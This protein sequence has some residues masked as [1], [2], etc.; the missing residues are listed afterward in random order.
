MHFVSAARRNRCT[1]VFIWVLSNDIPTVAKIE[2]WLCGCYKCR[3]WHAVLSFWRIPHSF[4]LCC[5]RRSPQSSPALRE[6]CPD[7]VSP[8]LSFRC[9]LQLPI[10][11]APYSLGLQHQDFCEFFVR[12]WDGGFL[13]PS[14]SW[15]TCLLR[16][17]ATGIMALSIVSCTEVQGIFHLFQRWL[18]LF[19]PWIFRTRS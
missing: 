5:P 2:S 13:G 1:V 4:E 14:P 12:F 9:Q 6:C 7:A 11:C 10:W 19:T 15:F 16:V 18:L 17:L 8:R 3:G